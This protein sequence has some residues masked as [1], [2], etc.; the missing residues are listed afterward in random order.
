MCF[1]C[2]ISLVNVCGCTEKSRDELETMLLHQLEA[3]QRLSEDIT[4]LFIY[5]HFLFTNEQAHKK[6]SI[7]RRFC[8]CGDAEMKMHRGTHYVSSQQQIVD[9]TKSE[10]F[11]Q[12]AHSLTKRNLD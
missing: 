5:S 12:P 3:V 1:H 11:P 8:R 2:T 10:V 4:I 6:N 9:T 7:I